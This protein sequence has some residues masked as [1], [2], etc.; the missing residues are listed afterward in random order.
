MKSFNHDM[1]KSIPFGPKSR[2]DDV[3][4][5]LDLWGRTIVITG[6]NSDIGFETFPCARSPWW[7]RHRPRANTGGS[8]GRVS[9]GRRI[10]DACR[11]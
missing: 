5:G 3:L 4:A 11:L 2:A 10:V 1:T 7:A 6:C 8:T 9:A